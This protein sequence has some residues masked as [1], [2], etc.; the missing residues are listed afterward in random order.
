MATWNN[1]VPQGRAGTGNATI[2]N[3]PV[4]AQYANQLAS[5]RERE[6]R[7]ALLKQRE[8]EK[9]AQSF[10]DN[11]LA[12]SE[13]RLWADQVGKLEQDHIQ[14]G[15]DLKQKGIDPYGSSTDAL[16]YQKERRRVQSQQGY[17]KA[18]EAQ[19][20][21]LIK[22]VQTK[23]VENF[24]PGDIATLN[25]FVS[26]G[27][28][29]DA[30]AG[31]LQLPTIRERFSPN[32][33]LKDV[34]AIT[35]NDV[36]VNGNK[37][38]D[39]KFIDKEATQQLILGRLNSDPRGQQF[40]NKITGGVPVQQLMSIPKT[41]EENKAQIIEEYQGNPQ[42]RQQLASSQG[43]IGE[44]EKFNQ[45][46]D[47]TA[48]SRAGARN[49][50]DT[51]MDTFVAN[52]SNGLM[53]WDKETP[54]M[55]VANYKLKEQANRIA[56]DREARLAS[57]DVNP[58]DYTVERVDLMTKAIVDDDGKVVKGGQPKKAATLEKSVAIRSVAFPSTQI[59]LAFDVDSGKN[60]K[61]DAKSDL[62]LARI[63]WMDVK[64][65]NSDKLFKKR[66]AILIDSD[67]KELIV[68]EDKVP[69]DIRKTK[70]YDSA[71]QALGEAPGATAAPAQSG[72]PK[73]GD[74]KAVQGGTAEFDGTKW[75]M[76]Q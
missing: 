8:A 49:N 25:K 43:I 15:I 73:K 27:K 37:K 68:T 57:G 11:Q 2:F 7:D 38:S 54:D 19:Y 32:T 24:E 42:L 9:L 47:Q 33:L 51:Q 71:L 65:V 76:K 34:K 62:K 39:K 74:T 41:I 4:V 48:R 56:R 26:E 5:L 64:L 44:G 40:I 67:G 10:R 29:S 18:Q 45:W 61:I 6:Q 52:S 30:Y 55:T 14:K 28:L 75:V 60:V 3:N 36:D 58:S 35:Q 46:V 66:M 50:F 22:Q 13:G 1:T 17:R 21:A 72:L 16:N 23:G 53:L 59:Q 31:D 69:I 12:A 63:G 20:N 70:A